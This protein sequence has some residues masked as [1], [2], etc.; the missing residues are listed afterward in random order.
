VLDRYEQQLA[1]QQR[2][3]SWLRF[4]SPAILMQDALN[5]ISGSGTTRHRHF[6]AQVSAYHS[7]WRDYFVPLIF[8]KAQLSGYS[9]LP[10]FAYEE[11]PMSAV[12]SRVSTSLVGLAIPALLLGGVGWYQ[13]RRYPVVA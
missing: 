13:L 5:D 1:S 12:V 6:M 4:M 8:R 3:V 11:E 2:L 10:V 7:E 9:D